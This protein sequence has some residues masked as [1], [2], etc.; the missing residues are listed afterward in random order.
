[1]LRVLV[2]SGP[3]LNLLG[4]R[5]PEVYGAGTLAG[6]EASVAELAGE[7]GVETGFAQSNHEGELVDL[8]QRAQGDYDAVV[9]NPGAFTH[10]SYAVRDAVSSIGIPVVEVHLS[11]VHGREEFRRTSVIAPVC[12][13]QIAGFGAESYHLGLRAAVSAALAAAKDSEKE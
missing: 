10:Y 13:G 8:L 9:F 11:N 1:M 5:E 2:L 6:I 3:N 12:V 4:S 7:L